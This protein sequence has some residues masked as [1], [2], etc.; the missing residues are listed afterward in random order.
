MYIDKTMAEFD[1]DGSGFI[2]RHELSILMTRMASGKMPAIR[3]VDFV[4]FKVF[5]KM[6][7]RIPPR[8][9]LLKSLPGTSKCISKSM[10]F[11]LAHFKF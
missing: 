8:N 4:L 2:G 9:S 7:A 1:D 10:H 3:D 5:K 6:H 11:V